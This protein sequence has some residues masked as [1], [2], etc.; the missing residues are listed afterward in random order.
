MKHIALVSAVLA[1]TGTALTAGSMPG[2]SLGLVD[3][4]ADNVVTIEEYVTG[5]GQL[6][7]PLDANGNGRIEWSEAEVTMTRGVF[8]GADTNGDGV[9]SRSEF[10]AELRKEFRFAD[11]DGDGILD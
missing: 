4:N 11:K 6:F 10:D 7:G 3:G 5:V 1:A 8:D 9:I 2:S